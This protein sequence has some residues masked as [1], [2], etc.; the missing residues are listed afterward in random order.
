MERI[1]LIIFMLTIWACGDD[2]SASGGG[3][4][5]GGADGGAGSAT[6]S[7]A[8]TAGVGGSP[9]DAC[10][11]RAIPKQGSV[12]ACLSSPLCTVVL[13][14]AG[15][16]DVCTTTCK[17]D[18]SCLEGDKCHIETIDDGICLHSCE[19]EACEAPLRCEDGVCRP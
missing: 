9:P 7:Q 10:P 11:P 14:G 12:G 2:S 16:V 1:A 8:S 4:G 5:S 19:V 18:L 13:H 17:L 3:G 15:A 6:T